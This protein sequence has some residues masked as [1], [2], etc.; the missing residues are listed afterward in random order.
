MRAQIYLFLSTRDLSVYE[1]DKGRMRCLERFQDDEPGRAAFAAFVEAHAHAFYYLM[2]DGFDEDFQLISIPKLNYRDRA[3]MLERKLDQ[4]Y[5]ASPFRFYFSQGLEKVGPRKEERV[6]L[7]GLTNP[8]TL[9]HWLDPLLAAECR[10]VGVYSTALVTSRLMKRYDHVVPHRLLV[11]RQQGSGLRQSYFLQNGVKFSRL[12]VVDDNLAYGGQVLS[13]VMRARQYLLSTRS[14]GRG[15]VLEV[16]VMGNAAELAELAEVCISDEQVSYAFV[17]YDDMAQR[18]GLLAPAPDQT[19]EVLL[20]Q[21]IA[22]KNI[23]NLYAPPS[24]TRF[25]DYWRKGR[26]ILAAAAVVVVLGAL[27]G[28]WQY[29]QEKQIQ[30]QTLSVQQDT[31]SIRQEIERLLGLAKGQLAD[32]AVMKALADS[33]EAMVLRWPQFRPD[34]NTVSAALEKDDK[35]YLTQ[36]NWGVGDTADYLPQ[37]DAG[38]QTASAPEDGAAVETPV[39]EQYIVMIIEGFVLDAQLTD[40]AALA[41][42]DQLIKRLKTEPGVEVSAIALPLDTRMDGELKRSLQYPAAA[43]A[44]PQPFRLKWVKKVVAAGGQP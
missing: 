17:N 42:V 19:A 9:A 37:G 10:L 27:G 8:D 33:Y 3:R 2:V 36:V 25:Y 38:A 20:L 21:G 28:G 31:Q 18:L 1:P 7:A 40:R 44:P 35:V 26:D 34:L 12:S 29:W 24:H 39:G 32:P 14:L 13:E 6:L 22:K 30:Q 5:R 16:M 43:E 23:H 11:S 41:H 15:D 4:H